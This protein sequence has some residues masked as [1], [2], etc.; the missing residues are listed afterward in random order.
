M[1]NTMTAD[2]ARFDLDTINGRDNLRQH[3]REAL[4]PEA[5]DDNAAFFSLG[6]EAHFINEIVDGELKEA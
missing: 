4:Q 6:F 3:M 2:T 1:N 5:W